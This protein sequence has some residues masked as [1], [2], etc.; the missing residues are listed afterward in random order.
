[1]Y[2]F[3]YLKARNEIG[4]KWSLYNF[5]SKSSKPKILE[6]KTNSDLSSELLKKYFI[7]LK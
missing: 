4:L 7:N 3:D 2:G 1:M 6:I 5:F